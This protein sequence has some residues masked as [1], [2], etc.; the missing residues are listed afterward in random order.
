ME[1]ALYWTQ[2]KR[3]EG[4]TGAQESQWSSVPYRSKG[5]APRSQNRCDKGRQKWSRSEDPPVSSRNH[6][7][8]HP[9]EPPEDSG[10]NRRK[11]ALV[12]IICKI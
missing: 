11:Q 3:D 2:Q 6:R 5:P 7:W 9:W 1:P 4:A 12:N 8:E 10:Q